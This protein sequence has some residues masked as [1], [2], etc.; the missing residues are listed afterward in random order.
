MTG[1][2]IPLEA[3]LLD[4]AISMTKGCASGRKSS[5][6]LH[7]GGGRVAKRLVKLRFDPKSRRP[8]PRRCAFFEGREVGRVTSAAVSPLQKRVIALGYVHRDQAAPGVRVS[9]APDA[10]WHRAEIVGL[11]G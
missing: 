7:R 11:A 6:A 8:S 1:D 4:R 9:L 10:G 5:F 3:G 2:T